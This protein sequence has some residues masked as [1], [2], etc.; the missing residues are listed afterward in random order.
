VNGGTLRV[1]PNDVVTGKRDGGQGGSWRACT[2]T[3]GTNFY[4]DQSKSDGKDHYF[5]P[6]PI[7]TENRRS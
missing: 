3:L 7:L 6:L 2:D 4:F 1:G 5:S